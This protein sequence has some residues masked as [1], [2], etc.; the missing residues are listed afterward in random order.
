MR[1]YVFLVKILCSRIFYVDWEK[2][3]KLLEVD[4]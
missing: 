2:E 4:L 1:I 3:K